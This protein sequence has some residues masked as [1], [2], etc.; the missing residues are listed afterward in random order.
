MRWELLFFVLSL[1]A[2]LLG[3]SL[4][5]AFIARYLVPNATRVDIVYTACEVT[6]IRP[7][8]HNHTGIAQHDSTCLTVAIAH[9]LDNTTIAHGYLYAEKPHQHTSPCFCLHCDP[10]LD[11]SGSMTWGGRKEKL[12]I[13]DQLS[14]FYRMSELSK[15]S[16]MNVGGD[17]ESFDSNWFLFNVMFWPTSLFVTGFVSLF[18]ASVNLL[19]LGACKSVLSGSSSCCLK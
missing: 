7:Q 2:T 12:S 16:P 1:L 3:L 6:H 4:V 18:F 11:E 5:F 9:R 19:H 13:G 8:H 14:C 17:E 15:N 10:R